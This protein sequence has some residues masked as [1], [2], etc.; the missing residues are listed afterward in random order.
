MT[1][2]TTSLVICGLFAALTVICAFITI[3]LGFTPVPVNFAVLAVFLA[4]GITG[5]KYGT[6]SI[7]VYILLGAV[8]LPVFA[9]FK[10][11]LGVIAGPTGGYIAGYL[12]AAFIVGLLTDILYK[13][14]INTGKIKYKGIAIFL[15]LDIIMAVGLAACYFL[16]TCWFIISTGTNIGAAMISCVLPFLPGDAIK[17]FIA[18]LLIHKLRPMANRYI[19]SNIQ[20]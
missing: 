11:G 19:Y 5:K 13:K 12:A 16:G 6:I 15:I 14:Y 8:G 1:K 18:S 9:G 2:K 3:P 10:G 20:K 17:I 4:S 7:G